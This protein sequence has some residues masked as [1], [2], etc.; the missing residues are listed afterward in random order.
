[1]YKKANRTETVVAFRK[2][3]NKVPADLL[4]RA[5]IKMST[6]PE[7]FLALRSHF[8]SSHAL[9]CISHWLL[10]IGDRHLENFMVAMETGSVI[11]ID[12]GH[13]F[14]TATQFL[15]TPELMPFRLTR[16]FVSLMLPMKETG[17][18]CMVMVHALRAFRSRAGLLTDTM[19]IFVKEPSFDWK[20]FEQTMQ[21]KGG[22][23]IKEINVNEK[24]WYSQHKIRYAKRKLAGANPAVIT[25]DELRLGHGTSP[26]FLSY[27][28]VARGNKDYN[29][30]AQEP[31]SGLSE[32]TQVKCLVDQATDPNILGRTWQGWEPWM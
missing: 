31:E 6:S 15:P 23:W 25:C 27:T 7:A 2:R 8:A 32:E 17:L 14:G 18:M 5:F 13:A 20:G 26:A 4:K 24:N 21:R 22:S 12:F 16:Q 28:A 1:M 3:E 19:E 11:G 9:L 30:R 29:I 10:G